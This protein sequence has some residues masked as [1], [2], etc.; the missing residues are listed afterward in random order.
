[1]IVKIMNPAGSDF[2][3]VNYNDKKIKEILFFISVKGSILIS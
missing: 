3:G 1:M 2:P